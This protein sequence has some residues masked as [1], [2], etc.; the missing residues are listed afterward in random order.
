[1]I[2]MNLQKRKRLTHL[3]NKLKIAGWGRVGEEM[4]RGRDLQGVW[5]GHGRIAIFKTD[6]QTSIKIKK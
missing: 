4:D 1:M 5:D 2:Q 3:E 6:N